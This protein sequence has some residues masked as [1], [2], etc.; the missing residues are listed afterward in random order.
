[1]GAD[2]P[3]FV[4]GV[5]RSGTTLLRQMLRGSPTLAI[6][7]ESH[8]VP[9]ALEAPTPAAALDVVL[10][11][12]HLA[13]WEIDPEAVRRR[14]ASAANPAAVVRAAFETYADAKGKRR[15]GDKTPGYVAHIDL[16][17]RAFPD[18]LFV[19]I[20]RDGREVADSLREQRWG[21]P[22]LLIAAYA[23]RMWVRAGRDA[24]E[25]LG[26]SRYHEIAYEDLAAAPAETLTRVCAF[27][28]E[29][30]VLDEMFDYATRAAGEHAVL[31]HLHRHIAKPPTPGLRDWRANCSPDEQLDIE[32]IMG[33]QL[34]RFGYQPSPASQTP[35]RRVRAES[36]LYVRRARA[37]FGRERRSSSR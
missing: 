27:L 11:S 34:V 13:T 8:F 31:P 3:V 24:G 33:P 17:A 12:P 16:L 30:V 35:W 23:W 32:A 20:V 18:A 9:R 15:W 7:R 26:P 37:R 5:P 2:A 22:N 14:A 21:P 25:R 36:K 28:G 19:H 4:V 6:P 1:M 29:D 10:S